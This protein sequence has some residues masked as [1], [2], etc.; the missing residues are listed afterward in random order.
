MKKYRNKLEMNELEELD[1]EIIN[2]TRNIVHSE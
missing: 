1:E 2:A